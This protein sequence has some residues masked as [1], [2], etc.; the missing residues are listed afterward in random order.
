MRRWKLLIIVPVLGILLPGACEKK[1]SEPPPQ[2]TIPCNVVIVLKGGFDGVGIRTNVGCRLT[3]DEVRSYME[4]LNKK[5]SF[6]GANVRLAYNDP[7]LVWPN[8]S[9]DNRPERFIDWL[10]F[11][12]D[13]TNNLSINRFDPNKIN[14][15]FTGTFYFDD[16]SADKNNGN[17]IDPSGTMIFGGGI[18]I[19]P[20]IM[21]SDRGY[22][23][24][25]FPPPDGVRVVLS[26]FVL[27]HEICHFLIRQQQGVNPNARYDGAEHDA[28]PGATH[29]MKRAVPHGA[30]STAD[31][32]EAKARISTAN[33]WLQP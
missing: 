13:I 24:G 20:H 9:W 10:Q 14:I 7:P 30:V 11:S 28:T 18:N 29:L 4:Q 1:P 16:P 26:D 19:R 12:M 6:Y 3:F 5:A 33:G 27:E 25:G 8:L 22:N 31:F 32:K 2:I 23:L 15:Y 17:T 21:I